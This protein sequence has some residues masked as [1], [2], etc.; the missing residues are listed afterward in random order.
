MIIDEVSSILLLNGLAKYVQRFHDNEIDFE[1]F[2][3]LTTSD[4]EKMKIPIGPRLI[5]E[6]EIQR[7]LN[8]PRLGQ[9]KEVSSVGEFTP[10]SPTENTEDLKARLDLIVSLQK[11]NIVQRNLDVIA[12]VL[13]F[14]RPGIPIYDNAAR[15]PVSEQQR[16][17]RFQLLS[18]FCRTSG[19][20]KGRAKHVLYHAAGVCRKCLHDN[21]SKTDDCAFCH[22]ES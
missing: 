18:S 14:H 1:S 12:V 8:R 17:E 4:L 2:Q 9:K 11:T 7:L 19:E 16:G 13:G 10:L 6:R 15:A 20:L 5:I 3:L 21:C 22:Y